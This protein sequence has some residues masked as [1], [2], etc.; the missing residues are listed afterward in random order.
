MPASSNTVVVFA[1]SSF[2]VVG[3]NR[4]AISYILARNSLAS[5]EVASFVVLPAMAIDFSIFGD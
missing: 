3:C 2:P 5:T 1:L 4:L